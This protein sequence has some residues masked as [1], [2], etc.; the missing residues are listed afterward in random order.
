MMNP[1]FVLPLYT[2]RGDQYKNKLF[3][4]IIKREGYS[5]LNYHR[6]RQNLLEFTLWTRR[7]RRILKLLFLKTIFLNICMCITLKQYDFDLN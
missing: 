4:L 3:T 2:G 7:P 1:F 5:L 6:R